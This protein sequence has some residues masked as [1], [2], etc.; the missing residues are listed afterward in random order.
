MIPIY[1]EDPITWKKVTVPYEIV[2]YCSDFTKINP[3]DENNNFIEQLRLVDCYW[4]NMGYYDV[5]PAFD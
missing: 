1:V 2:R 5:I 3:F 4:M